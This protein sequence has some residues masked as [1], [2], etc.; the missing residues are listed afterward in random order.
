[1]AR[2]I[3][4]TF[5]AL[6]CACGLRVQV[7]QGF[8]GV[9]ERLLPPHTQSIAV[10]DLCLSRLWRSPL[11]RLE[12]LCLLFGGCLG[13]FPAPVRF[14]HP[15]ER[16]AHGVCLPASLFGSLA[17]LFVD[18]QGLAQRLD[19]VSGRFPLCHRWR[20]PAARIRPRVAQVLPK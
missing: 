11:E 2:T 10:P 19:Q 17:L 8:A 4:A 1:M 6:A 16:L 7:H 15:G 12:H 20:S 3:P 5:S 13:A 9:A 18:R 14:Q